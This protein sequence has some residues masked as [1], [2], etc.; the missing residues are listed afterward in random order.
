MAGP[1][2]RRVRV[3]RGF[4]YREP[5]G[6]AVTDVQTRHR[7]EQLAIPPAWTDVWICP[8]ENGH[9]LATGVDRAGR[10]QYIYHPMW[11]ARMDSIK[12]DRA[13]ALAKSLP[14][15]R[16]RV[17]A[18]LRRPQSDKTRALAAAFRMLDQ[19]SLRVGSER[20]AVEHG[21]H[22]LATLL[23]AH[24]QVA[25]ADIQLNFPG[26]SGQEWSSTIHDR[27]LAR[28][29]IRM[30]QRAPTARLL[31]FRE[32]PRGRWHPLTAQDINEYVKGLAGDKFTAKDFRTLRGTIAAAI[33]LAE[34]G[35]LRTAAGRREA[36]AHAVATASEVLGNTPAI[37]RRSYIDP[38]LIDAYE[39]GDTIDPHRTHAAESEIL[40]L[41]SKT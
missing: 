24:A 1:G 9:V 14:G 2:Y 37:A 41:I 17:T 21:S 32:S 33:E 23:C 6:S 31:A 13:L 16:R 34:A 7:F 25:G 28:V 30:K 8:Y 27:D 5:D 40:A 35:P 26:K 22:G 29:I 38:R 3:G 11:R 12:F 18:D 20:Y 4:S 15:A 19:G 39:N 36:I 10:R